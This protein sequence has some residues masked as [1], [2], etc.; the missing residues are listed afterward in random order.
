MKRS[1]FILFGLILAAFVLASSCTQSVLSG[2]DERGGERLATTGTAEIAIPAMS[3]RIFESLGKSYPATEVS[4]SASQESRAFIAASTVSLSYYKYDATTYSYNWVRDNTV[5]PYVGTQS[6]SAPVTISTDIFDSGEYQVYVWVYNSYTDSYYPVV[7]GNAYFTITAG[8]TTNVVITCIPSSATSIDYNNSEASKYYFYAKTPWQS[9]GGFGAENWFQFYATSVNT[10]VHVQPDASSLTGNSL[11]VSLYDQNGYY[12]AQANGGIDGTAVLQRITSPGSLYYVSV[13]DGGPSYSS[14]NANIW[15]QQP[16]TV[17][18]EASVISDYGVWKDFVLTQAAPSVWK[19]FYA[20]AGV[21]Y[22]VYWN[23]SYNGDGTKS[24]DIY[25]SA[26]D[27][28]DNVYTYP[29]DYGPYSFYQVDSGYSTPKLITPTV[30][31]IVQI[32][33][34][35]YYSGSIDGTYGLKIIPRGVTNPL[36]KHAA[37]SNAAITYWGQTSK[38]TSLNVPVT[39]DFLPGWKFDFDTAYATVYGTRIDLA[40]GSVRMVGDESH[41]SST[42]STMTMTQEGFNHTVTSN[43]FL[44][45]KFN[46]RDYSGNDAYWP[47]YDAP[48]KIWLKFNDAW[49]LFQVFTPN[50]AED[51]NEGYI[52]TWQPQD[53]IINVG[54]H[55]TVDGYSLYAGVVIQGVRAEAGGYRWD[56]ELNELS[57]FNID[58]NNGIVNVNVQ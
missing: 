27:D 48:L 33:V 9:S 13:I 18:V 3:G 57:L 15:F 11:I 34:T 22:D 41:S 50:R 29:T 55:Y 14:R 54:S 56:T 4:R 51:P 25:V 20:S 36:F 53:R 40:S 46:L 37:F 21:G 43:T 30:D 45:I 49:H 31:D 2:T 32:N 38:D 44:K 47:D 17:S 7:T 5:Y 19:T 1:T 26:Y 8:Q 35:P 24:K 39:G 6:A 58:A 10:E 52:S 16:T 23:D 28:L 42:R 12:L